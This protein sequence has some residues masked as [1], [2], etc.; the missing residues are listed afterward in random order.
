MITMNYSLE[1]FKKESNKTQLKMLKLWDDAYYNTDTPLIDDSLY[2]LCLSYYNAKNPENKYQS[3]LGDVSDKYV[4]Y[5]H[6]YPVLSLRKITTKDEYL[7]VMQKFN[8]STVIQPKID[9]LTVVYYPDGKLVTRGNGSIGEVLLHADKIPGLPK[10]LEDNPVRLEVYLPKKTFNEKYSDGKNPR[11]VAAGILRL[12]KYSS[13]ILDLRYLAY[14]IMGSTKTEEDQILVLSQKGFNT[15]KSNVVCGKIIAESF[16]DKLKD[17]NKDNDF[18]TDGVV[19]KS[20]EQMSLQR[21][22]LTSHHPNNMV[23]FKFQSLIKNT[24]LREIQWSPGRNKYTPVAVFDP[25][26]LNGATVSCASVHNVNIMNKLNLKIGAKI[27][28]TLKNEIIPQVVDCD[29][30]GEPIKIIEKCNHCGKNLIQDDSGSIICTNPECSMTFVHT[31]GKILSRGGL[32]VKGLSSAKIDDIY[33]LLKKRNKTNPFEVLKLTNSDFKELGFTEYSSMKLVSSINLA[34]SCVDPINFIVACNIPNVGKTTAKEILDFYDMDFNKFLNEFKNTGM[35]ISNI[36]RVTYDS[37]AENLKYIKDS[38]KY[39]CLKE[40][41]KSNNSRYKIAITGTLSIKRN[42]A[43][44][45]IVDAGHDF[46]SSITKNCTHLVAEDVH[47]TSSKIEKARK[48]N[49]KII[50][51][52]EFLELLK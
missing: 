16:Y 11:N 14:N 28:V 36:G 47:G 21:H 8:Y 2:D 24:I 31:L 1:T 45:M 22:G 9:G 29:G 17:I 18:E 52:K 7:G 5:N 15:V 10:P 43:E 50:S 44:K 12:K 41:F 48:L 40:S 38:L 39:V 35:S 51:E 13:N 3:S 37:I 34:R 6:T 33:E 26:E 19:I 49:I 27:M 23:A 25:V 4:K 30:D 42:V 46:S 32:D 20:N